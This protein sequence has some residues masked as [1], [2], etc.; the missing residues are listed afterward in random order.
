VLNVI[1]NAF[2]GFTGSSKGEFVGFAN[3]V[4]IH[5]EIPK[6]IETTLIWT[7]GSVIPAIIIGLILALLLEKNFYLKKLFLALNLLPYSI[8][9]IIVASFWLFVFNQN[10]GILNGFLQ[11]VGIISKPIT[12]LNYNNALS[13]VIVARIWRATPFAFINIYAAL[14]TIPTELYEAACVD[15]A[16]P[17]QRFW[18]ITLPNLK[19]VLST[20]LIVLTVWTFLVFDIIYGMTGGGPVDATRIISIQIYKEL[21]YMK[22]LGTAS[23]WSLLAIV[24]LTIITIIYWILFE[25]KEEK[26]D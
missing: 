10:F 15:G 7:M 17:S 14:T 16:N 20:T 13:S 5:T 25:R 23:M 4:K 3:F 22:D 11:E 18:R 21:F 1:V 24:I 12:F 6:T 2:T 8:P 9:L 26:Y 19:S